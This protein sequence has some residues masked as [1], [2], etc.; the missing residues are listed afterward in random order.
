[1][2][3]ENSEIDMN[4]A[5]EVKNRYQAELLSKPGVV[6]IGAAYMG[7]RPHVIIYIKSDSPSRVHALP[8][9]LEEV[10]VSIRVL[11]NPQG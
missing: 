8:S 6:W 4:R 9:H 10:P 11:S 1:M 3:A 5:I 7:K 2:N